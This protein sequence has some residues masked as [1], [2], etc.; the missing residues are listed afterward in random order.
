MRSGPHDVTLSYDE[1]VAVC[2]LVAEAA[3]AA[4][5]EEPLGDTWA[6][7]F[8]LMIELVLGRTDD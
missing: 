6:D 7:E 5:D 1:A 3:D 8:R 2:L 4:R